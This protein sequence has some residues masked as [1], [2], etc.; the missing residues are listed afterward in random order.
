MDKKH[1]PP[2][3]S[4]LNSPEQRFHVVNVRPISDPSHLKSAKVTVPE[5]ISKYYEV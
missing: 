4:V 2:D 1:Y 5:K 3:S